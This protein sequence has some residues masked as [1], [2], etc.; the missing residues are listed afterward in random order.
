MTARRDHKADEPYPR[1]AWKR[2]GDVVF[3]ARLTNQ[4]QGWFKGY[5]LDEPDWPDWLR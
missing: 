2:V 5:P 4:E 3:E 1:Y